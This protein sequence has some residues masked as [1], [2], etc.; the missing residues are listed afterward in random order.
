[1][2]SSAVS[3]GGGVPASL[4]GVSPVRVPSPDP[5]GVG[6]GCG[7]QEPVPVGGV[8]RV[9]PR[10]FSAEEKRAHVL[11]YVQTPYGH[12][13]HYLE[14][15]SIG[16]DAMKRW[17]SALADGDLA[18]GRVPRHTGEVTNRDVG[19]IRRLQGEVARL[20][21]ERDEARL[22]ARRMG[23]AADALGKAISV[24]QTMHGATCG[25]DESS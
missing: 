16:A 14:A 15:H 19:E 4:G 2:S 10:V 9:E 5:A 20:E 6:A 17:K 23:R 12:K 13:S 7:A 11:A 18:G 8:V 22:E 24:M 3:S 25:E 1:M 21:R